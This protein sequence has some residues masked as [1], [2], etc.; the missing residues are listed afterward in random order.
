MSDEHS[1]E[2]VALAQ[3]EGVTTGGG[4]TLAGHGWEHCVVEAARA[5]EHRGSVA[6]EKMLIGDHGFIALVND[7]KRSMIGAHLIQQP[8]G[9]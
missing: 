8:L 6:Q 5:A 4:G 7:I 9:R 3:M 2:S 1:S